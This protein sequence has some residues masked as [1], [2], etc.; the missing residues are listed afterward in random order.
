MRGNAAGT[1]GTV[2]FL[3]ILLVAGI[4]F[5]EPLI[6][7]IADNTDTENYISW[8]YNELDLLLPAFGLI[9]FGMIGTLVMVV[10]KTAR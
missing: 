7:E 8:L 1:F 6:V 10:T 3:L 4:F 5:A 2:L 9:L